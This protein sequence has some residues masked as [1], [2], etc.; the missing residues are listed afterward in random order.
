MTDT[1][2]ALATAPGRAAVAVVRISGPDTRP[3]LA[4]LGARNLRDRRASLRRLVGPGGETLDHALTLWFPGPGSYTGEDSGELHLH[5]GAAVVDAVLTSLVVLGARPAEPGEFTRRAFENGRLD[6]DQAEAVGDLI[7]AES[8]AQARQA[9][10]QLEGALGRRYRGWRERLVQVLARL[11]A[12]V[13]F[14]DEDIPAEIEAQ[15]R[16]PLEDLVAELDA[17]LED[18]ARGQRIRDGYRVAV[19]GAPNA[20]KS[21]LLNGLA[22]RDA[23]IVTG[24][25]GTTRDVIEVPLLSGG[26]RIVMADMAGLRETSDEVEAEGVRRA[27]SWAKSADL[28]I[29]VIDRAAETDS[30]RLARELARPSDL[31]VINKSDLPGT[32]EGDLAIEA[33]A[34]LGMERVDACLRDLEAHGVKAALEKKVALDLTGADFPATTRI[35]HARRLSEAC[36][37]LKRAI[38]MTA[39]PELAAEDVRLAARSLALIT[40]A[41][42]VEDVLG[43]VFGTFCIGK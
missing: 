13:D 25:A 3:I 27:R 18:G 15:A 43:E 7:D 17:A 16:A 40:G 39:Q 2:C 32:R 5:G 21:S 11:E 1:I 30:W 12:A 8:A 31:A 10:S 6:L 4:R 14:P 26:Y 33:A 34:A 9:V 37:H 42:G 29:W 38:E 20:G 41:I 23:A 28:R 24:I 19:I 36:A 22:E 35:R